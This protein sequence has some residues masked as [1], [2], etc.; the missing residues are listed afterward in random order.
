VLPVDRPPLA[1]PNP[2]RAPC[3]LQFPSA[4]IQLWLNIS[5]NN[6]Q[7]FSADLREQTAF[8]RSSYDVTME[9]TATYTLDARTGLELNINIFSSFFASAASNQAFGLDGG[10]FVLTGENYGSASG[11]TVAD[12][13]FY[14][15]DPDVAELFDISI[16]S[17]DEFSL[18]AGVRQPAQPPSQVPSPASL[19]LIG[20]GFA[21]LGWKRRNSLRS[22]PRVDPA[23][24]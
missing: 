14:F 9:G 3:E 2:G 16:T 1:A 6:G 10:E 18:Q 22:L 21:D 17:P 19:F 5:G 11:F 24:C 23:L 4:A 8:D 12:P 20:I 7:A 15:D 13:T